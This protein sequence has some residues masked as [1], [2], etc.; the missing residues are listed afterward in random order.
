MAKYFISYIWWHTKYP[1]EVN[2]ENVTT[3][4]TPISWLLE[5]R[6]INKEIADEETHTPDAVFILF[7]SEISNEDYYKA[8]EVELGE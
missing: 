8:K 6:K 2:Y 7:Y 3:D 5:M 1:R 4:K